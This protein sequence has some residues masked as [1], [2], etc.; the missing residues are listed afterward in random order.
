MLIRS[1]GGRF[2]SSGNAG[3][4]APSIPPATLLRTDKREGTNFRADYTTPADFYEVFESDARSLYLLGCSIKRVVPVRARGLR[5]LP[6]PDA[7]FFT[8]PESHGVS[9]VN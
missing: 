3:L 9:P 2:L 8:W 7:L 5:R 6:A 1:I 4:G